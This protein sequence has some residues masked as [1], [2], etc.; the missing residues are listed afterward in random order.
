MYPE[1]PVFLMA[2]ALFLPSVNSDR[3]EYCYEKCMTDRIRLESSKTIDA[4][5]EYEKVV[6]KVEPN[7]VKLTSTDPEPLIRRHSRDL[8]YPRNGKTFKSGKFLIK[9]FPIVASPIYVDPQPGNEGKYLF[10]LHTTFIKHSTRL[11]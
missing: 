3:N 8:T 1:F 4:Y 5:L 2:L 10:P 11:G 6:V 9:T 7:E